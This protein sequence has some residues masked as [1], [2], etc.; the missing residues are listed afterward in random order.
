MA[1]EQEYSLECEL[2][3][4]EYS[5]L[6]LIFDGVDNATSNRGTSVIFIYDNANIDSQLLGQYEPYENIKKRTVFTTRGAAYLATD[7]YKVLKKKSFHSVLLDK[8]LLIDVLGV[9]FSDSIEINTVFDIDTPPPI[10]HINRK[11]IHLQQCPEVRWSIEERIIAKSVSAQYYLTIELETD[12]SHKIN[13]FVNHLNYGFRLLKLNKL[14]KYNQR[15]NYIHLPDLLKYAGTLKFTRPFVEVAG[16]PTHYIRKSYKLD[17]SR[18]IILLMPTSYLIIDRAHGRVYGGGHDLN[19][20]FY[21]AGFVETFAEQT[22]YL[23][24]LLYCISSVCKKSGSLSIDIITSI[25]FMSRLPKELSKGLFRNV[26]NH[27]Y[28]ALAATSD[29]LPVDGTLYY[30]FQYIYKNKITS[31]IDFVVFLRDWVLEIIATDKKIKKKHFYSYLEQNVP[32]TK[33]DCDHL[34]GRENLLTGLLKIYDSTKKE[35]ILINQCLP[36]HINVR[37]PNASVEW[38]FKNKDMLILNNFVVVEAAYNPPH[39]LL[40]THKRHKN[41]SNTLNY[42]SEIVFST[43]P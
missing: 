7:Q 11:F 36:E 12:D 22:S 4:T 31:T 40:I 28:E 2:T 8:D 20:S 27:R 1:R 15:L 21:Y 39:D 29:A 5:D 26:W 17:G 34:Y 6:M 43:L 30:T 9:R 16:E 37:W 10:L 24:D 25:K 41:S 33:K 32:L 18:N 14:I 13:T 3:V 38:F 42:A 19:L 23:I 35:F